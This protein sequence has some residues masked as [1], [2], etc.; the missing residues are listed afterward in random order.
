MTFSTEE[1]AE[2]RSPAPLP[3]GVTPFQ[4]GFLSVQELTYITCHEA[5]LF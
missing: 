3:L 2:A 5:P 4:G 1:P